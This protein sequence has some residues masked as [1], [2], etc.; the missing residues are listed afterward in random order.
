MI[1]F[2]RPNF[3]QDS[4]GALRSFPPSFPTVPRQRFERTSLLG[5]GESARLGAFC[6]P[7]SAELGFQGRDNPPGPGVVNA[8]RRPQPREGEDQLGVPGKPKIA[9]RWA[10]V[11]LISPGPPSRECRPRKLGARDPV[12]PPLKKPFVS[13]N[14]PGFFFAAP[15]PKKENGSSRPG[16]PRGGPRWGAFLA[17]LC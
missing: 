1:W 17:L 4:P 2:S 6:F 12:P 7:P 11:R 10:L 8:P 15:T 14:R 9:N 3:Y 13:E 16:G 5:R